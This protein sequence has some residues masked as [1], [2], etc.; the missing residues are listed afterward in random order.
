MKLKMVFLGLMM[1]APV[2][3]GDTA[4]SR[5]EP[6]PDPENPTNLSVTIVNDNKQRFGSGAPATDPFDCTGYSGSKLK[7]KMAE[8]SAAHCKA[9]LARM[10]SRDRLLYQGSLDGDDAEGLL[11]KLGHHR[12]V[13]TREYPWAELFFDTLEEKAEAAE[14]AREAARKHDKESTFVAIGLGVLMAMF[15]IG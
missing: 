3:A 6:K 7:Y 10:E 1:C 9:N 8:L 2:N 13:M 5:I 4:S 14:R 12:T 11:K 15:G